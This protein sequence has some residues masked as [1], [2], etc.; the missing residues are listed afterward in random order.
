[1]MNRVEHPFVLRGVL[2]LILIIKGIVI[3]VLFEVTEFLL[4]IFFPH[5]IH[6]NI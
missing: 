1:M 3:L 6:W 4:Y 2:L 5:Q